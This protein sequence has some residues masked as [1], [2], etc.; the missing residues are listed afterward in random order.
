MDVFLSLWFFPGDSWKWSPLLA[1]VLLVTVSGPSTTHSS[2]TSAVLVQTLLGMNFLCPSTQYSCE[3][4]LAG[5]WMDIFGVDE[6][7]H[8]PVYGQLVIVSLTVTR[9][10]FLFRYVYLNKGKSVCLENS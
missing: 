10:S 4:V 1:E 2:E 3:I 5:T 7:H 6:P 9:Q 8:S